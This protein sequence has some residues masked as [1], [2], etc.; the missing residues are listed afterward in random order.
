MIRI[1]KAWSQNTKCNSLMAVILI[2][3][4]MLKQANLATHSMKTKTPPLGEAHF[5]FIEVP[6]GFEPL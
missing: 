3:I 4:L 6:S 2:F 5:V 1:G